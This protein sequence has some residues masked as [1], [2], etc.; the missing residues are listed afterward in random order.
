MKCFP[1]DLYFSSHDTE[2]LHQH[3]YSCTDHSVL[4]TFILNGMQGIIDRPLTHRLSV[5]T[6]RQLHRSIVG[7]SQH[8]QYMWF[9]LLCS[10][11]H[12][13]L[14]RLLRKVWVSCRWPLHLPVPSLRQSRWC[15]GTENQKCQFARWTGGSWYRRNNTRSHRI[16]SIPTMRH[17]S[18]ATNGAYRCR[19]C[20]ILHHTSEG[21]LW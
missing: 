4:N 3:K 16:N 10:S 19:V 6:Y 9:T 17:D 11:T 5:Q 14:S 2:K 1:D 13:E 21:I 12:C 18:R 15:S 8:S 20:C 7:C